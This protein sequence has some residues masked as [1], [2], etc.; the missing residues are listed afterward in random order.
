MPQISFRLRVVVCLVALLAGA[1]LANGSS[2][3]Q[4]T[5]L[6]VP[7][8]Y[9]NRVL[10][11]NFPVANGQAANV[12]LGQSNFN[13]AASGTSAT[14]M[15]SP[16]ATAVDELGNLYVSDTENCRVLQFP[17]PLTNGEAAHLVIGQ[18]NLNTG[19]GGTASASTLGHTGAVAFDQAGNLWVADTG[20]SRVLRF[21]P[22]FKTG[23]AANLV[24]G[25][26][27]FI[28]GGCVYPP[29]AST[30]CY[31]TG[32]AFDNH[33][34][35]W[36]AD[37]SNNRVLEFKAPQ[38]NTANLELGQPAATAFTS[39]TENNGGISASS[40][41]G[42]EQI[43]FDPQDELWVADAQNSR[44]LQFDPNFHN[45]G[46]AFLVL[47]Q[48]D[49][50]SGSSNQGLSTPNAGTLSYPYGIVIEG[51]QGLWVGDT[52]NN[53]TL[54]FAAP[55]SNGTPAATVLGQPDFAS[56]Q[57]NQGNANPGSQTQNYPFYNAGASLIALGML[58]GLILGRQWI[59]RPRSRV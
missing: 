59:L 12:V 34:Y 18:A 24:V 3:F 19:C 28:S 17:P 22:P 21:K 27:N 4:T 14:A 37:S 5:S 46:A 2:R 1:V 31:P 16:S 44:V 32:L 30:L 50:T 33:N 7:D 43:G 26:T 29:T 45:G 10:I 20:N 11:Y 8:A 6:A 41:F 48:T 13:N 51:D 38:T 47:G 9:N 52:S 58:G 23:E 36:V 53:R 35:L 40:L 39:A 55:A 54:E 49:F 15:S 25:Q 57:A 42:P 56:N